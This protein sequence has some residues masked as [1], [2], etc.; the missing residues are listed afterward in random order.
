MLPATKKRGAR[1]HNGVAGW[2]EIGGQRC[3]FRSKLERRHAEFL[4]IQRGAGLISAWEHEPSTFGFPGRLQ[5]PVNYKP[6]FRVTRPGG[7]AEGGMIWGASQEW[8]E[9]KGHWTRR[10][11]TKIRLMAR[12]YPEIRILIV[13]T[14][15]SQADVAKVEAARALTMRERAKA[16]RKARKG[17]AA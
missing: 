17:L 3:Y 5:A 14:P 11:V 7:I 2:A 8:H 15:L 4:E 12:H 9:C 10:D 16:E 1:K 6:D 13:G